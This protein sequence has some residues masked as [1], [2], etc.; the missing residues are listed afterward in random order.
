[1]IHDTMQYVHLN[2]TVIISYQNYF[3]RFLTPIVRIK[4]FLFEEELSRKKNIIRQN[5]ENEDFFVWGEIII[6]QIL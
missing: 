4:T 6:R 3:L 2:K 5:L 1:M